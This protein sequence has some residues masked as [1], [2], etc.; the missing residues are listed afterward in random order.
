MVAFL[1]N[2]GYFKR[3]Y[4][5]KRENLVGGHS[6][7]YRHGGKAEGDELKV[8][9]YCYTATGCLGSEYSYHVATLGLSASAAPLPGASWATRSS[10]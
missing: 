2:L 10:F 4:G 5:G 3:G 7:G 6:V 9:L 1:W 8:T